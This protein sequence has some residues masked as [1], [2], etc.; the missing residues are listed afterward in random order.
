MH[1]VRPGPIRCVF[2]LPHFGQ[3]CP[4][5]RSRARWSRSPTMRTGGGLRGNLFGA[6][7]TCRQRHWNGLAARGGSAPR[8]GREIFRQ[9][10]APRPQNTGSIPG[11]RQ[12]RGGGKDPLASRY[13]FRHGPLGA[14]L[15]QVLGQGF[16]KH[17]LLASRP[18][19]GDSR[20]AV[21]LDADGAY[22]CLFW[23]R[24]GPPQP[25]GEVGR[26]SRWPAARSARVGPPG[27]SQ[28]IGSS[29]RGSVKDRLDARGPILKSFA[30][31]VA[32]DLARTLGLEPARG[33]LEV[34]ADAEEPGG[35]ERCRRP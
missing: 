13:D 18:S 3:G 8:R 21:S 16:V 6:L 30:D 28:G 25:R 12:R 10:K 24:T 14:A 7:A 5:F 4:L 1:P 32:G 20:P 9:I 17:G 27:A 15:L 31:A 19:A 29:A 11:V 34:G 35:L 33:L 23:C 26:G 2:A 22:R